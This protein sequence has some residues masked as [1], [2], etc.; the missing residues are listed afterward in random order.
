M[1]ESS[2]EETAQEKKI[3]LAKSFIQKIENCE[4]M[5]F[6]SRASF[7]RMIYNVL[8]RIFQVKESQE[9]DQDQTAFVSRRLEEDLVRRQF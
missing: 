1:T 8:Y 9:N 7:S 5:T 4:F 6:D 3:R 2:D